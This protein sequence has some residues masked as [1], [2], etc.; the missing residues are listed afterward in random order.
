MVT[1]ATVFDLIEQLS[2]SL[3][4]DPAKVSEILG[5]PLEHDPE[6]DSPVLTSYTQPASVSGS[7]FKAVEL[8]IPH[9]IF[10]KGAGLLSVTLQSDEGLDSSAVLDHYGLKFQQDV[11][12]PR[13][14]KD[15]PAY[16]AYEQPWGEL[17]LGVTNDKAGRLV[18]FVMN[19]KELPS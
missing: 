19:P 16:F 8:R 10:G 12:S 14:A 6:V 4:L 17:S 9:P 18:S 15:T 13:Y 7:R 11:P 2:L 5:V 3:P 1:D